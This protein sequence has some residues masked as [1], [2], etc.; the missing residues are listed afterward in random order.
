VFVAD[1]YGRLWRLHPVSNSAPSFEENYERTTVQTRAEE[2]PAS[3]SPCQVAADAGDVF[4]SGWNTGPVLAYEASQFEPAPGTPRYGD[5]LPTRG[6]SS[7][8]DPP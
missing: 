7:A 2:G 3:L 5:P 8:M 4:A 6:G 1:Y